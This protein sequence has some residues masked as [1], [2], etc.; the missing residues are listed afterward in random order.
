[1]HT[2]HDAAENAIHP[3]PYG[4]AFLVDD[5]CTVLLIGDTE[6]NQVQSKS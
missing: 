4:F 3:K 6:L 1:M 2:Y 5:E